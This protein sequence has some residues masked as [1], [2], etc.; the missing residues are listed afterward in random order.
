MYDV[1]E[2]RPAWRACF[3]VLALGLLAASSCARCKD[4]GASSDESPR[5]KRRSPARDECPRYA[6]EYCAR[7]RIC[8]VR[9]LE[10]FYGDDERCDEAVRRFCD[11]ELHAPSGGD[12]QETLAKC[13]EGVSSV[14]CNDWYVGLVGDACYPKGQLANGQPCGLRAQCASYFCKIP[15]GE[16]CGVC[17]PIPE[18]GDS[19]PDNQCA[20]GFVCDRFKKCRKLSRESEL[21]ADDRGCRA[22][23]ACGYDGL[24]HKPAAT[25]D[26]CDGT[27]YT[28]PG[29]NWRIGD[30]CVSG[31]CKKTPLKKEGEAC[32]SRADCAGGYCDS[33][34]SRCVLFK[35]VGD[36]C[37]RSSKYGNTCLYPGE[38]IDGRC[39]IPDLT[40]CR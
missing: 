36:R 37:E 35:S 7:L 3:A 2:M 20:R 5:R 1:R 26:A 33:T 17:R 11:Y 21:C 16:P 6:R 31:T 27:W 18:E 13:A 29:C 28:A 22:G 19:C 40:K 34:T 15:E 25:G 39:E 23:L 38:C 4:D 10:Y 12:T 8:D 32:V 9:S 30:G 14:D 24:C